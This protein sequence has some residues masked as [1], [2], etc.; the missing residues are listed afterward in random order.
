MYTYTHAHTHTHTHTN[1]PS[2]G[3]LDMSNDKGVAIKKM[4]SWGAGVWVSFRG[5]A[6]LELYH[7]VTRV[8]LQQ[9]DIKGTLTQLID[10][11]IIWTL[12][13]SQE[14]G[15]GDYYYAPWYAVW[16]L[17]SLVNPSNL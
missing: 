14:K 10:S 3:K 4:T 6:T 16:P 11:K 13:R 1:T 8:S 2:Q 5:S 7:S 9:I 12:L 15:S 17:E